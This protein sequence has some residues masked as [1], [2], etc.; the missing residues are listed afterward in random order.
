MAVEAEVVEGGRGDGLVHVHVCARVC[1]QACVRIYISVCTSIVYVIRGR[2][3][4]VY[5]IRGQ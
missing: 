2:T 1:L 4:I 3:S 5:V